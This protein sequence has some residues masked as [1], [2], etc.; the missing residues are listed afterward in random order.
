M[1]EAD[2]TPSTLA[3]VGFSWQSFDLTWP[4][5][6]RPAAVLCGRHAHGMG[7][8]EV[9]G[10]RLGLFGPAQPDRVRLAGAQVRQ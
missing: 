7:L 10:R 9:G 3:T 8:L 1:V 4:R 5:A 2:L 6:L